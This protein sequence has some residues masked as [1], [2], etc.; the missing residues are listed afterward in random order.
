V[1]VELLWTVG[2]TTKVNAAALVSVSF[3]TIAC[4]CVFDASDHHS[5]DGRN[6]AT[7]S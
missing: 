2:A 1:V 4:A 7:C 6:A 3:A 5:F